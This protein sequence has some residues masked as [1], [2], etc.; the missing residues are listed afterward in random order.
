MIAHNSKFK[1]EYC[2]ML[3]DWMAQGNSYTS[4]GAMKEGETITFKT[5]Y[6]WERDYP[7]WK[8]SKEIGYAKGLA[9]YES[10]MKGAMMGVVP[11]NIAKLGSK[12]LD[13]TMIIFVLKTRFCAEYGEVTRV[14]YENE[15]QAEKVMTAEEKLEALEIY[16]AKIQEELDSEK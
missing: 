11:P 10:L 15:N 8:K 3:I 4:W 7:D 6:N 12:K 2:Q 1:P 5:Q 9:F 16:K 13:V 14:K